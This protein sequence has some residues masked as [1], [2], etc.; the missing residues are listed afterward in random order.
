[1]TPPRVAGDASPPGHLIVL[2]GPDGAGKSVQAT[3]LAERL[4]GR[5]LRVTLTREPGGTRLG[6]QVR[7]I[8]LD[9]SDVARGPIADALLFAAARSQHVIEVIRP[10][11]ERGE[12][13]ICDRY[14][15][16]SMAYQGYGSGVDLDVLTNVQAWATGGLWPDLVVLVDVPVGVG[17]ARRDL[18]RAAELTRF[19]DETR[20]DLAFHQ[21]VRDGYLEMAAADPERWVVVNGSAPA[22]EVAAAI[23]RR[24]EEALVR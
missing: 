10:A 13:V 19:E 14:V 6:E 24:V 18:G 12:V 3:R 1:M 7:A 15:A 22:D 5:G 9:P 2:E 21:R 8:L 4:A 11:L 20:H 17:L 16:S 23:S